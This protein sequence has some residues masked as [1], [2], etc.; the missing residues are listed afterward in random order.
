MATAF[1][2]YEGNI[3]SKVLEKGFRLVAVQTPHFK[4]CCYRS[5]L[6]QQNICNLQIVHECAHFGV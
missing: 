6:K 1:F 5:R 3:L 4:K 2:I